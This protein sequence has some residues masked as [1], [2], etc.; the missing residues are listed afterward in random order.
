MSGTPAFDH[1]SKIVTSVGLNQL[2]AVSGNVCRLGRGSWLEGSSCARSS[3]I[4]S[5][6]RMGLITTCKKRRLEMNR[7]IKLGITIAAMAIM[8]VMLPTL[9]KPAQSQNGATPPEAPAGFDNVTNGH[10]SQGEFDMFRGTFEEE[11]EIEEGLGPTFNNTA[12]GN[13]H[14]VPVTG[15]SSRQFETRAGYS[16]ANGT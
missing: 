12:C 14:N 7:S 10:I 8:L 2:P 15:G 9:Q 5:E 16:D 1:A 4:C 6:A 11:E 3:L 13:C